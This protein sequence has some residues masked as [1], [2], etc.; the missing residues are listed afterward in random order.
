MTR[1]VIVGATSGLGLATA[2]CCIRRGWRVGIAGRRA[3][4]L[5][6]LRA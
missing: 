1:I 6:A 2:R 4:L 5:E 3:E